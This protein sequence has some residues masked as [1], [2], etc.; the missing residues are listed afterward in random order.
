M[1]KETL[2]DGAPWIGKPALHDYIARLGL[3][4]AKIGRRKY[5]GDAQL[6]YEDFLTSQRVHQ[7]KYDLRLQLRRVAVADALGKLP[8]G[9]VVVDVGCGVGEVLSALTLV[10]TG[11]GIEYSKRHLALAK[12]LC[13][14]RTSLIRASSYSLPIRTR[15][16]DAV[17]CLEV[18]E[19]LEDDQAAL[20]EISRLLKPGG[21]L[22][23]SVP[24]AYYFPEYLTLLGHYRH[25]TRQGLTA[26]LQ[27]AQFRVVQYVEDYPLVQKLH[28]YPYVVFAGCHHILNRCGWQADSM[29]TR[30]I[31]GRLYQ[32]I[33][34]A[35]SVLKRQRSQFELASDQRSTFLVAEKIS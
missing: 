1:P 8:P 20:L 5:Q 27:R 19:H 4:L 30:P 13:S 28:Y 6:F 10:R 35:L 25:Y 16:V 31:L 7:S 23:I 29:Y 9:A 21:Q 33:S 17:I 22:V 11:V 26:L 32:M 14:D 15:C 12:E 24:Y 18:I 2:Q 3:H 34:R